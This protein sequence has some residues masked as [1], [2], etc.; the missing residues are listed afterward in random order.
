MSPRQ[1]KSAGK[2]NRT[3]GPRLGRPRLADGAGRERLSARVAPRTL[4]YLARMTTACGSLGL[5]IDHACD[6]AATFG[7]A[8]SGPLDNA[9]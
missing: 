1:K 9:R 6:V 5:A 8:I 3:K 4:A 7:N 2:G